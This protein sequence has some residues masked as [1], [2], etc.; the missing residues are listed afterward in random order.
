MT[1]EATEV[2][3]DI[4][5]AINAV[6][7]MG[8]RKYRYI[9]LTGSSRSSKTFSLIDTFDLYARQH[10][11]KRL[12]VWRDTKVD[13]KQTVL[14]DVLKHLKNTGRYE[15]GNEYN[16]TESVL[17]Y[18]TGSTFEI[19]GT[20][21]TNKVHGLTQ[22]A[23]WFNEPYKISEAT[24]NQIDQRTSDF[25]FIDWN[26]KQKH[27]I[28]KLAANPRAIVLHSTFLKNRFC[29]DESRRKL[30]SYQPV[31]RS[32]AVESK[33]LELPEALVYDIIM[34]PKQLSRKHLG[35]LA[36]CLHNEFM[37]TA[38][39]FDWS[40]YGLG[41][42]GERPNRIFRF[43]EIPDE[44]F[45]NLNVQTYTGVDWG[46][47]DPFGIVDVKY[48]DGALYLHE[49]NYASENLIMDRLTNTERIQI[50]GEEYG[51]VIWLFKQ[52]GIPYDREIVA[53]N[54]RQEK[55]T[56]IRNA[57][58]EYARAAL[59]PPGSLIEG[60]EALTK[61]TVYYTKSSVNLASEQESYSRKVDRQ[62]T[63][64]E[65]PEDTNNHLMDAIRY[66][67]AYLR[68]I[69]VIKIV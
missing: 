41:E 37:G 14:V 64:L 18:Q 21:D 69:G 56:A 45:H 6:T 51:I 68:Q 36:R 44:T 55:I 58:Y 11:N 61:L 39:D 67:A 47:V 5:N 40:V 32:Y 63:V 29:P 35:E 52:L 7:D 50:A 53:D 38:N 3:E 30:L 10:A 28:D 22:S 59:K 2:F 9:I 27:W 34:N 62:G 49:R 1:L 48:Y 43:K 57:G 46:K 54:N 8:V 31:S 4:W 23:A 16:K 26:P 20:D 15:Q 42:K 65:E 24:F 60:V 66:V 33:L 17:T 25:I 12:T 19:H 13:C